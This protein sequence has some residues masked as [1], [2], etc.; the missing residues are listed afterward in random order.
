MRQTTVWAFEALP[1]LDGQTGF[2]PVEAELAAELIAA[3]KVQDPRVGGVSLKCRRISG[4]VGSY[5]Y[6]TKEL[7]PKAKG[8]K[9][10]KE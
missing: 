3:G 4:M 7:K 5:E 9:K 2:V 6:S 1:E 10:V 8:M